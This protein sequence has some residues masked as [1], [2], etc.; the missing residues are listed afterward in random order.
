KT[1]ARYEN[2][3]QKRRTKMKKKSV[4][5]VLIFCCFLFGITC[6]SFSGDAKSGKEFQGSAMPQI[7]AE[8]INCEALLGE[9]KPAVF[10]PNVCSSEIVTRIGYEWDY[11]RRKYEEC[12]F[13]GS[14]SEC[15]QRLYAEMI[16]CQAVDG[17]FF[18]DEQIRTRI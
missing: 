6:F 5:C 17:K 7:A 14:E 13:L 3:G 4:I 10:N 2:C 15:F 16:L 1:N 18:S 12:H 9:S 8:S 11:A